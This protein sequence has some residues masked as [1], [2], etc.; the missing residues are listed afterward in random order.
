MISMRLV[1][2]RMALVPLLDMPATR[3][4]PGGKLPSEGDF[5]QLLRGKVEESGC[6]RVF[7]GIGDL[8]CTIRKDKCQCDGGE[9]VGLEAGGE[10]E[11][12]GSGGPRRGKDTVRSPHHSLYPKQTPLISI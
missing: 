3:D 6:F 9:D 1:D 2:F 11:E 12:G 8:C 4:I 10:V 7:R 5:L